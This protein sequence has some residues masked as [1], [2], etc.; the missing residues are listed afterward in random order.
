MKKITIS[1]PCH[2]NWSE[3]TP[4]QKGAFCGKCQI[5]VID[6]ST[7]SNN[8]IKETLAKNNGN[9]MC[10]RFAQAQLD[11]FNYEYYLWQNQSQNI[12]QSKF[13]F[14]L[15]L[16]FGLTLF[17]CSKKNKSLAVSQIDNLVVLKK[18][19]TK[20]NFI[21][22]E[23]DS[24]NV[25]PNIP[26]KELSK[27]KKCP[28]DF[29]MDDI[30]VDYYDEREMIMGKMPIQEYHNKEIMMK[31]K[32]DV[33]PEIITSTILENNQI[34]VSGMITLNKEPIALS[35]KAV[36]TVINV[37]VENNN[38][39]SLTDKYKINLYPNPTK[40]NATININILV[41]EN[42][43]ISIYDNQWRIVKM[44][45]NGILETG[46]SKFT[47]DLNNQEN[48]IYFIKIMAGTQNEALKLIK[49]N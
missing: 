22:G 28:T 1:E 19:K 4:T 23:I 34:M 45:Q 47:I 16:V 24:I 15:V 21:R 31:E 30:D 20:N 41:K 43:I 48:G 13:I 42:Y 37:T 36:D 39:I 8:E 9:R 11:D 26:K 38:V 40:N 32:I 44:I 49:T 25:N 12:L 10:G 5:N 3:F 6:F 29:E 35:L 7:K 46:I 2:E 17:S 27:E 33:E 18:N 14:A